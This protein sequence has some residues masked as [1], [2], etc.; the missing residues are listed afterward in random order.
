MSAKCLKFWEYD[1][2]APLTCP[3]C[4][5]IGRAAANED[6]HDDL[7]DVCCPECDRVLLIVSFPTI[8]EPR[9]AA[10]AGNPRAQAELRNVDVVDVFHVRAQ[11]AE[12]KHP[13]Q[14]TTLEGDRLL[15]VWDFEEHD[16]G[17]WT[18]LRH[19]GQEIWRELAYYEGYERFAV[20]L[21][22]L[23]ERYGTRL[24]EVQPTPASGLYLYG[25]DLSA[26]MIVAR[27]NKSLQG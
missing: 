1:R 23:R 3:S 17:K 27:L 26:P 6:H 9:A 16:D 4:G 25:D 24:L 11:Q 7:I 14:L 8:S 10:A 12:L 2:E 5:W 13:S 21:G 22:I 20:V 18:V 19:N 15:I